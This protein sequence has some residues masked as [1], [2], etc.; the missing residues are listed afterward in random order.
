LDFGLESESAELL[1]NVI[2]R[3][4]VI[5][6]PDWAGRSR[7]RFY[8]L[9]RALGGELGRSRRGR[10]GSWR[11]LKPNPE[12]YHQPDSEPRKKRRG[13]TRSGPLHFSAFNSKSIFTS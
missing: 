5:G 3:R 1:N 2:P 4:G 7:N 12:S 13:K 6:G 8:V 10:D 11:L 9:Y